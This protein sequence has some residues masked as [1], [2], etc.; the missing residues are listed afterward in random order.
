MQVLALTLIKISILSFY[1][2]I[3]RGRAFNIT[4]WILI[5]VAVAW[6]LTFFIVQ[7][8]AC[9]T[10][11]AAQW[12]SLASLKGKCVNTFDVLIALSVFDVAVDLAI[13]I[14]PIP[15]VRNLQTADRHRKY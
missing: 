4:S 9:G 3:F 1:R 8:A 14:M 7:F 15:L 13:L 12:S 10:S 6:G 5:G 11:L 2:R